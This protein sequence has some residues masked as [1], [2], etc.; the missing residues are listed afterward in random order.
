MAAPPASVRTVANPLLH[1]L[2]DTLVAGVR[3][4][5]TDLSARQLTV[6]LKVYLELGTEHTARGSASDLNVSKPAIT[7]ALDRF[8]ESD[9]TKR[10]TDPN[11]MPI[12]SHDLIGRWRFA[13]MRSVSA[14]RPHYRRNARCGS[15]GPAPKPSFPRDL[16]AARANSVH[17]TLDHALAA[18]VT[19]RREACASNSPGTTTH[20]NLTC[21]SLPPHTGAAGRPGPAASPCRRALGRFRALRASREGMTVNYTSASISRWPEPA[22]R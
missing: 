14:S 21:R 5:G 17:V 11:W 3:S 22:G 15:A 19:R 2:K 7:R 10:E 6:L 4:D 20:A 18:T 8:A 9:F 13:T 12:H 1:I 16:S